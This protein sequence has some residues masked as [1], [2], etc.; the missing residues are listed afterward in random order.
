MKV[1]VAGAM[2]HLPGHLASGSA[3][4]F[5]RLGHEVAIHDYL[6]FRDHPIWKIGNRARLRCRPLAR[7]L[8]PS[9]RRE[10]LEAVRRFRPDLLLTISGE[11]FDTETIGR[12]RALGVR[13]VLWTGDDP[14]QRGR[15]LIAAPAYDRVYV[16]DPWYVPVLRANGVRNPGYL[17][18]AVDPTLYRPI[19][20][21][22]EERTRLGGGVCFVGTYYPNRDHLLRDLRDFPLKIWGGGWP[23]AVARPGHPLRPF[24]QGRA[25]GEEVV[26]IYC[27][28]RVAVNIQHPQSRDGQNMRTFE[29]PAC[30]VLTFTESTAEL[31]RLFEID[32]E[33]VAYDSLDALRAQLRHYLDHPEQA[34]RIA[35]RGMTR[36]RAEH[37]YT[38]RI[39]R[40]LEEIR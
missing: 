29:A 5:E 1:L 22:E 26:R 32:E 10:L 21:D 40:V 11:V 2:T 4:A 16:F 30:G 35:E 3:R 9:R 18:M 17:P 20:L 14:Y 8:Y 7:V 34:R 6:H 38:N 13:T 15:E 28:H 36:A 39:R 19:A 12:I 24:Y 27:G 33:I 23:L 25:F 31:P 37:T